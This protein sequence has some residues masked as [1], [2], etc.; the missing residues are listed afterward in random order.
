MWRKYLLGLVSAGIVLSG[1]S[2][3]VEEGAEKDEKTEQQ[4]SKDYLE[5]FEGNFGHVHG[6]GYMKD[7]F[8]FA[9]HTG[10]KVYD[11][12]EWKEAIHHPHDYMG[13]QVTEDGFLSSGHPI[14]NSDLENPLG[15]QKGTLE[16]EDLEALAF[17]KES[18]FHVMGAG[19]ANPSVYIFNE[20]PNSELE[21][22]FY[23]SPDRGNTWEPFDA[24]G[25]EGG[26]FQIAVHP[27]DEEKVAVAT[28][29]GVFL[30]ENGGGS[31]EMIS[32]AG[33]GGGLYF[34]E[35]TLFFGLYKGEASM[36]SYTLDDATTSSISLPE[37]SEDAVMY[38]AKEGDQMALYTFNGAAYYSEDG[39]GNWDKIA[40][41]G[42]T[43]S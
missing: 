14:P 15:L 33:Q 7:G 19:Y 1:C 30:S 23:K 9:A 39:G 3:E 27:T 25:I 13:F 29:S 5:S 28:D 17:Y 18:D 43:V 32:E 6:L 35:E 38:F 24:A 12:E 34:S 42:E 40:E 20:Q 31:F 11:G 4:E 10:L 41:E 8:A 21:Q 37:M 22:G 2:Q 26:I 36:I 16:E